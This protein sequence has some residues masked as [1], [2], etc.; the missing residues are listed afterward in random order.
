[1]IDP[2]PWMNRP[3]PGRSAERL[4]LSPEDRARFEAA[5]RPASVEKRIM[6]RAQAVLWMADGMAGAHIAMLLGVEPSTICRWRRRFTGPQP[7]ERL[8]DAPRS[9]RPPS[10][11]RRRIARA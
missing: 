2:T 11:S 5:L 9:G 6:Q 8:A 4:E 10:L 3:H 1:M 7:T